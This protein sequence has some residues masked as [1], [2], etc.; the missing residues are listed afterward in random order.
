MDAGNEGS[1]EK[2]GSTGIEMERRRVKDLRRIRR[3]RV[4]TRIVSGGSDVES[5]SE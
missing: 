1:A 3:F 2:T 5:E 4:R